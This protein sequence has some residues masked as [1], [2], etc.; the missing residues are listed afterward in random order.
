MDLECRILSLQRTLA[1]LIA[2]KETTTAR[3]NAYRYPALTLPNEITSEIFLQFNP[4]YPSCPPLTGSF[5]PTLLT[6]ICRKWRNIALSVPS[7]W[8]AISCDVREVEEQCRLVETWLSRSGRCPLALRLTTSFRYGTS[9]A[10]RI[11]TAALSHIGRWEHISIRSVPHDALVLPVDT[12]MPLLR[13][14]ELSVDWPYHPPLLG[15][16]SHDVPRLTSVV[17]GVFSYSNGRDL[18]PWSQLTSLTLLRQTASQCAAILIC[19]VNL[20][21]CELT[22]QKTHDTQLVIRLPRLESLVMIPCEEDSFTGERHSQYL[23]PFVVPALRCLQV[24]GGC[25][26]YVESLIA[27]SGCE[28]QELRISGRNVIEDD[29][30]DAFPSIP[31]ILFNPDLTHYAPLSDFGT[32]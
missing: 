21:Y 14:L 6:R 30:L 10:E 18:L 24:P 4:P 32:P 7:L 8:R 1:E 16:I 20:V 23:I 15:A 31:T 29:I 17:L 2:E 27:A 11:M 25:V 12:P 13:S 3:L 19:A 28:L 9:T 26:G 22:L 5:S